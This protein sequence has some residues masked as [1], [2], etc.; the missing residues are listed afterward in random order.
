MVCSSAPRTTYDGI[1]SSHT[2]IKKWSQDQSS[3]PRMHSPEYVLQI[4][5]PPCFMLWFLVKNRWLLSKTVSTF[6]SILDRNFIKNCANT[7][8]GSPGENTLY[9]STFHHFCIFDLCYLVLKPI[10][11]SELFDYLIYIGLHAT[12][13]IHPI[14]IFHTEITICKN[15]ILNREMFKLRYIDQTFLPL[16]VATRTVIKAVET[17]KNFICL[18]LKKPDNRQSRINSVRQC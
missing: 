6:V 9:W 18:M 10:S 8:G 1:H 13:W 17:T 4:S 12:V 15:I 11:Y 2:M 16:H 14:F 5:Q 3:S 7:C